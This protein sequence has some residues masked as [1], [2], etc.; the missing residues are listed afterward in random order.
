MA[1]RNILSLNIFKLI[2]KDS[3]MFLIGFGCYGA[4]ILVQYFEL[5]MRIANF[6]FTHAG[7][8]FLTHTPLLDNI[9]HKDGRLL[10][11]AG[12][13]ICLTGTLISFLPVGMSNKQ[14]SMWRYLLVSSV[15]SIA[16]IAIAKQYTT[17][18]CPWDITDFGGT[19]NYIGMEEMFAGNQPYGHCFPSGHASGG[20]AWFG[21]YFWALQYW[22]INKSQW[23]SHLV[24][25]APALLIGGSFAIAQ[26]LRGAHFLSHDLTTIG[27]CWL[28]CGLTRFAFFTPRQ[29]T[30]FQPESVA[31]EAR[32]SGY[33]YTT[34]R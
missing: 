3:N 16:V 5:D 21:L 8:Q 26:Q 24:W 18:P 1:T 19:R 2:A 6:I 25:L 17:L 11:A 12:V 23:R 27:T 33:S 30:T 14:K 31:L 29:L 28:V 10:T 15:L 22:L 9:F 20:F 32:Q 34:G 13:I 7:N 4:A